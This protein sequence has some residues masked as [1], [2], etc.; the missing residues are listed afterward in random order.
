MKK[1]LMLAGIIVVGSLMGCEEQNQSIADKETIQQEENTAPKEVQKNEDM[2]LIEGIDFI[3][4]NTGWFIDN[5]KGTTSSIF[6][7]K[8][9]GNNWAQ[10]KQ[11]ERFTN[12]LFQSQKKGWATAYSQCDLVDRNLSCEEA[13]I[14]H[15][16]DGGKTWDDTLNIATDAQNPRDGAQLSFISKS[17]GYALLNNQLYATQDRGETWNEL[18]FRDDSFSPRHISFHKHTGLVLGIKGKDVV[19]KRTENDGE[20][21]DTTFTSKHKTD[22]FDFAPIDVN[23]T[24]NEHAYFFYIDKTDY[25]SW[26][27]ASQDGGDT[28]NLRNDNLRG[29]RP[30]PQSLHFV[31]QNIGWIPYVVGAAG[32][33]QGVM[34]TTDGGK[35]FKDLEHTKNYLINLTYMDTVSPNEA[36]VVKTNNGRPGKD[37]IFLT[38]DQ[39]K[40]WSKIYPQN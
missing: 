26:L 36:L 34:L 15:T 9:G 2:T 30:T 17:T 25:R 18:D 27:Y 40:S 33:W 6:H 31:N 3:S 23:M 28:W 22:Y 11:D 8:D 14:L 37:K 32:S 5:H 4:K 21:W 13:H 10:Y 38:Q 19:I 20:S 29:M 35:T 39:G 12:I 16:D 7:T 24:D 1:A